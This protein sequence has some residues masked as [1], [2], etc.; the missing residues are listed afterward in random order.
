MSSTT[1]SPSKNDPAP[2]LAEALEPLTKPTVTTLSDTVTT[3]VQKFTDLAKQQ[4][5]QNKSKDEI[6]EGFLWSAWHA[7]FDA[8][9]KTPVD[10]QE[11]L[12]QFMLELKK[13]DVTAKTKDSEGKEVEVVLDS[14]HGS[15]LWKDLPLFGWEARERWNFIDFDSSPS[16]EERVQQYGWVGFLARLT[17]LVTKDI[18]ETLAED[19]PGDFS[20][21][22]LWSLRDSF[23]AG[24]F[25][26]ADGSL[27][28]GADAELA[29]LCV[30]QASLWIIFAG[31]YLWRLSKE[32]RDLPRR[33]GISDQ[34]FVDR[35]WKGFNQERW[36]VWKKGFEKAQGW[37]VGDEAKERVKAAVEVMVKLG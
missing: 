9:G 1:T 29:S 20:T 34:R 33:L 2:L 17:G 12:V 28:K 27:E 31:E 37:V 26:A 23:E 22:A 32:G 6:L 16:N 19:T 13:H 36:A 24:K 14:G 8:A 3:A 10:Q 11:G 30:K 25:T 18:K 4:H 5:E 7:V 15:K 21:Y 35:E